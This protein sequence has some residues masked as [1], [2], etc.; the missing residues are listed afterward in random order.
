MHQADCSSLASAH[1]A[2]CSPWQVLDYVTG[3]LMG[4]KGFLPNLWAGTTAACLTRMLAQQ[5]P[6][7][8]FQWG[9]LQQIVHTLRTR[10]RNAAWAVSQE[11]QQGRANPADAIS[12]L[13]LGALRISGDALSAAAGT[14]ASGSGATAVAAEDAAHVA[15]GSVSDAGAAQMQALGLV[16]QEWLASM[17]QSHYGKSTPKSDAEY[18]KSVLQYVPP[19]VLLANLPTATGKRGGDAF[20]P[21]QQ[22]HPLEHSSLKPEQVQP[23]WLDQVLK[24]LAGCSQGVPV[25]PAYVRFLQ[26]AGRALALLLPPGTAEATA[27]AAAAVKADT[28]GIRGTDRKTVKGLQQ[29]AAAGMSLVWPDWQQGV[30][31]VLLLRQRT[32]WYSSE[33]KAAEPAGTAAT[34]GA[35]SVVTWKPVQ[36]G[37]CVDLAAQRL[38]QALAEQLAAYKKARATQAK[39]RLVAAAAEALLQHAEDSAAASE[40]LGKIQLHLGPQATAGARAEQ[41]QGAGKGPAATLLG[42]TVMLLRRDV[43]AVIEYVKS[44]SSAMEVDGCAAPSAAITSSMLRA[45]V[46]GGWTS[47][48]PQGLRR[49]ASVMELCICFGEGCQDLLAAI[50]S[51]EKCK[52]PPG[53][54]R[55]SGHSSTLQYPGPA[56]WSQAYASERAAAV[57]L[58]PGV[59]CW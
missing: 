29:A 49:A 50:K 9:Q 22:M 7:T 35:P 8:E 15:G 17:V 41:R 45:L 26:Q 6:L 23:D 55:S 38:R 16:L 32:A 1:V 34:E 30:L 46:L 27:A 10:H 42:Q 2:C 13:L 4:A 53:Q 5:S 52:R 31:Q 3:V 57:A 33:T 18:L 43:P 19:D 44:Q 25:H 54:Y 58:H 40:A 51:M 28:S 56:N 14:A 47:Q 59:S 37:S 48:G 20:D 24:R 21:L 11:M 36:V 12:K 39:Q